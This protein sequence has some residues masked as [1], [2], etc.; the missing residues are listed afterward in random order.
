MIINWYASQI[1]LF[2]GKNN[3]TA[4][5]SRRTEER[6]DLNYG[7][8]FTLDKYCLYWFVDFYYC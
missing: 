5:L 3:R 6:L 2:S 8:D 4:M 1:C 7:K